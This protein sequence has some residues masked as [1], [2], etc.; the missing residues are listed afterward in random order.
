ML[1][2]LLL[3]LAPVSLAS[4]A[5]RA[6]TAQGLAAASFDPTKDA[7][8]T[9]PS[10]YRGKN[11]VLTLKGVIDG[12]GGPALKVMRGD[13]QVGTATW[14]YANQEVSY[15][16]DLGADGKFEVVWAPPADVLAALKAKY[17]G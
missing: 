12:N 6:T 3:A 15:L 10:S 8:A 2:A 13:K 7:W 1:L 4:Q 5:M 11:A 14:R 9:F 17:P 16:V